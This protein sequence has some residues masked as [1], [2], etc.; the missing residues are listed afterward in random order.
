MAERDVRPERSAI[1]HPS[2]LIPHPFTFHH[3]PQPDPRP[4]Q[5]TFNIAGGPAGQLAD[6]FH[7]MFVE[8]KEF[9]SDGILLVQL[10][11]RVLQQA[12]GF[13]FFKTGGVISITFLYLRRIFEGLPGHIT[14]DAQAIDRKG[15]RNFIQP[16]TEFIPARFSGQ[17]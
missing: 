11:D 4:A 14:F 16:G 12:V 17:E 6:F 7:A 10:A 15:N 3:R 1:P 8:V 9:Q 2:S 13:L 5:P